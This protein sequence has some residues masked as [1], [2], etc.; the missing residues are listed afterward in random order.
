M[1]LGQFAGLKGACWKIRGNTFEGRGIDTP[2]HTMVYTV[3]LF[4]EV[5]LLALSL[6]KGIIKN[7]QIVAWPHVGH[8]IKESRGFKGGRF[9]KKVITLTCQVW[10][11]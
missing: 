8:K 7:F 5:R 11:L 2:M 3:K 10:F 1:G 6:L 4:P 9:S